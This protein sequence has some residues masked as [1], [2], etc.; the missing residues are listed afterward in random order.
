[1]SR[2]LDWVALVRPLNLLLISVT[3]L[4]IWVSLILPL[5]TEAA[6]TARQVWWLGVAVALVA[7]GGNVVNDIADRTIDELNGRSNP[8]LR[9]VTVGEAWGIYTALTLGAAALSLKLAT[10]VGWLAGLLLLPLTVGLLLAYA[11]ALKCV[12]VVGNLVVAGLCAAVPALVL[13]VEPALLAALPAEVNAHA[14]LA[15]TVFAFAGTMA[16]ETVKDLQ[17]RDGDRLAGCRTLATEAPAPTVRRAALAWGA[18]ALAAVAY[19]SAVYY[20][21]DAGAAALGW[22]LVWGVLAVALWNVD[23]PRATPRET[24]AVVS[25]QLKW[26]LALALAV[27]VIYGRPSWEF[28][29]T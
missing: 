18:L 5:Y 16:R 10:E 11:F 26:T 14:M 19:I 4:A 2:F 8:L 21:T 15:Y 23:T 24:Y 1:M 7:G 3:P 22:L 29:G 12:P 28:V 13:L 17:D 9:G 27:L 20:R 25:R 6:L